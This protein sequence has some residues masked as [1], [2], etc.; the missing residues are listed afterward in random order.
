MKKGLEGVV[1][2]DTKISFIDGIQ[3]ILMY[4]GI[5]IEELV[6][7]PY[8]AVSY[9]LINGNLPD[10]SQLAEY[11]Q[12]LKNNRDINGKQI[13]VLK[14]FD[15]GVEALDGLRTALS[16]TAHFDLEN[17]HHS[18]D[19]NKNKAIKLV[20]KLPTIVA[21]LHRASFNEK[22]IQPDT[23]LSI[24]ANFLYMLS[25]KVPTDLEAEAME[26]SYPQC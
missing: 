17:N 20:A 26:R 16:C 14:E 18:P 8:D 13:D 24:G 11:S 7:L 5:K 2:L 9:L 21:A 12:E 25:G 15:F 3:G 6:D 22:P 10:D 19:A 23:E 1:A 4:R